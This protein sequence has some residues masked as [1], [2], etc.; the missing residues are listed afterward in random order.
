MDRR[1]VELAMH[2]DE[3]AFD[4]LIGRVGDHLH[5]VARRI[6]RDPYLAEDAT[7]RALLDAWLLDTGGGRLLIIRTTD[8]AGP[9][10]YE[11]SQGVAADRTRHALDQ[12]QLRAIVDSIR[13]AP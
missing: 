4:A 8:Y 1:L 11:E 10:P 3:A 5:S 12:V 7:Q 13:L 6:L 9:S 2:G